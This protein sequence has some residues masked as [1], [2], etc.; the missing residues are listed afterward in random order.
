MNPSFCCRTSI[1]PLAER[2]SVSISCSLKTSKD[3]SFRIRQVSILEKDRIQ[4]PS[5]WL[6]LH[7][8]ASWSLPQFPA[9]EQ[10]RLGC[11][12]LLTQ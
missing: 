7:H 1:W 6:S 9:L 5:S 4:H 12:V 10:D 3:C 11:R 2:A 8:T